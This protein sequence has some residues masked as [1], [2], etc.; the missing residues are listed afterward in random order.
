[1]TTTTS[2]SKQLRSAH[3]GE[4]WFKTAW[5]A[6]DVSMSVFLTHGYVSDFT[7]DAPTINPN[8][9]AEAI[10]AA[11]RDFEPAYAA[12]KAHPH[13]LANGGVPYVMINGSSYT[14]DRLLASEQDG[15]QLK[16]STKKVVIR[17]PKE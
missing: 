16:P 13:A 3:H 9:V 2:T 12:L 6:Y 10:F 7:M 5:L 17:M 15:Y 1:M 11:R 8:F 14:L 4:A